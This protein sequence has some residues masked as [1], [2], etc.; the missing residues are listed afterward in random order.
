MKITDLCPDI[1]EMV[2]HQVMRRRYRFVISYF[3]SMIPE[4]PPI[5]GE[6]LGLQ[7]IQP[8]CGRMAGRLR[9]ICFARKRCYLDNYQ[10]TLY[11]RD[12][13]LRH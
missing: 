5:S 11:M 4:I 9:K 6:F 7:Q 10:D 2:S 13:C 12:F 1:L 3:E 8:D